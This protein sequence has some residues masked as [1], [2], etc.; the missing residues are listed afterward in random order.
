MPEYYIDFQA[1]IKVEA[2]NEEGARDAGWIALWEMNLVSHSSE[3]TSIE[4][5]EEV[6]ENST[7]S[8]SK[9]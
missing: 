2:D 9:L 1:S 4:M 3:I 6:L 8:R 7:F 5:K